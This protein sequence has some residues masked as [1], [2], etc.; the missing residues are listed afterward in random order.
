VPMMTICSDEAAVIIV[1]VLSS[2]VAAEPCEP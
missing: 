2:T 1:C